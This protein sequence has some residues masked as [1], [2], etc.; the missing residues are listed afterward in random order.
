MTLCGY[1]AVRKILVLKYQIVTGY[2][3]ENAIGHNHIA[4]GL[5][6]ALNLTAELKIIGIKIAY[7]YTLCFKYSIACKVDITFN[8]AGL[9]CKQLSLDIA[10]NRTVYPN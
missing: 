3:A 10:K 8:H 1:L 6:V 7:D 4:I 5:Y 2:I 9:G